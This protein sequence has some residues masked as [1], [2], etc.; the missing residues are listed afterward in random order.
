MQPHSA[1]V[2]APDSEV[3]GG[4]DFLADADARVCQLVFGLV[5]SVFRRGDSKYIQRL[6]SYPEV[7]NCF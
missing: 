3:G 5:H 7:L 2:S 1:Q 6:T 4:V